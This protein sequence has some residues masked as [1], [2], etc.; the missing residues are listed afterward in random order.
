MQEVRAIVLDYLPYG[1]TKNKPIP[2]VQ[3]IGDTYFSLIEFIKPQELNVIILESVP[4]I[5]RYRLIKYEQLTPT[6]KDNLPVALEK[7]VSERE[8]EFIEFINKSIPITPRL[9]MLELLPHIGKRI[10]WKIIE[11]KEKEPFKSFKDIDERIKAKV[12]I[13]KSIVERI[14]EE[15]QNKDKYKLFVGP[16]SFLNKLKK[17]NK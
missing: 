6:A 14:I 8:N 17:L 9:H 5:K 10:T 1:K 4:L 7:L 16:N 15:L 12:D 3:A 13:K 2:I 11:E